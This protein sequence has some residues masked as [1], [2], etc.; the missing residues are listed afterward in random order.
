MRHRSV[1]WTILSALALC[2][3]LV[4]PSLAG[5]T[6]KTLSTNFTVVNLGDGQLTGRV[7]Y[8]Q[9]ETGDTWGDEGGEEINIPDF[10][11]Q[12][13]FRQYYGPDQPGN[14][15][16]TDGAGSVVITADKPMGAVVQI[17][18]RGQNPNSCGAYS[19]FTTG[20][21][22]WYVPLVLRYIHGG[23]T[24]SQIIVQNVGTDV[25]DVDI[26][27]VDASGNPVYTKTTS[28]L[29]A[30][31]S[32]LYDLEEESSSNVPDAYYGSAVVTA[33]SGGSIAVVSNLFSYHTLQTF[34]AFPPTAPAPSWGVP[35]FT[36]RLPNGLSTVLTVQNLSG[37]TIPAGGIVVD[38]YPD[39]A[40]PVAAFSMSNPTE[41]L[42]TA[43]TFF[44]PVTDHTIPENFWGAAVVTAPA[45]VVV[46][47]QMRVMV[48]S[49]TDEAGA[50]EA[51]S[52]DS[53]D[54]TVIVPLVAK[55]LA[56]GFATVVTIQNSSDVPATTTLTYT[57]SSAYGGSQTPLVFPDEEIGPRRSLMENHRLS[58][59]RGL[60]DGWYGTLTVTSDQP[61]NAF[62]QLTRLSSIDPNTP[63]G[64]NLMTH[65]AFTQP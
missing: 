38:C 60:P 48:G 62:V 41:L 19:G 7:R 10:G 5:A 18:A 52:L 35:L 49:V 56:N 55:R 2:I 13:I 17:Q 47:V 37:S 39:P 28:G 1:G 29:A 23:N 26:N 21:Q 44:N 57:P 11:G 51:F 58:A 33:A 32:F 16:L 14:P 9:A 65:S 6:D 20:D 34:N 54:T 64:D 42:H 43:S 27:L 31:A 45:D 50:Y 24:N 25:T 46:F 22:N 53:T 61:I 15:N 12:A 8:Y 30:G 36:S 63:D 4:G 59:T 40:S 3:A